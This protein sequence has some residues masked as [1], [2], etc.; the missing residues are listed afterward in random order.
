MLS[1]PLPPGCPPATVR[2]CHRANLAAR[3]P[4]PPGVCT[5][6][7]C[8]TQQ[9]CAKEPRA[10]GFTSSAFT[11]ICAW[12]LLAQEPC[13]QQPT[14][15]EE[16]GAQQTS[17]SKQS[18]LPSNPNYQ[19]IDFHCRKEFHGGGNLFQGHCEQEDP[20]AFVQE[21]PAQVKH[22]SCIRQSCTSGR[23]VPGTSLPTTT[24]LP[25]MGSHCSSV[26]EQI[27]HATPSSIPLG[28]L[29]PERCWPFIPTMWEWHICPYQLKPFYK[30]GEPRQQ[31][32]V[33]SLALSGS[34][35]LQSQKCHHQLCGISS[36]HGRLSRG[37]RD[38]CPVL[39]ALPSRRRASGV[40]RAPCTVPP[41][42]R[43]PQG[44]PPSS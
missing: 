3:S 22:M 19:A 30:W 26:T 14:F 13:A 41:M 9:P 28:L 24:P 32:S 43:H 34:R 40:G 37:K 25:A 2:L 36:G 44:P 27:H 17:C 39:G 42:S 7:I 35:S 12:A 23:S 16:A 38:R 21:Y 6:P 1:R 29:L 15:P 10:L 4:P 33:G 31:P 5:L 8:L 11:A 18:Q 20:I